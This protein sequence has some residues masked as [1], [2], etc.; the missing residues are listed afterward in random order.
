MKKKLECP[1][2]KECQQKI[3]ENDLDLCEGDFPE[4]NQ[5]DCFKYNDLGQ[6]VARRKGVHIVKTA[7]E[8]ERRHEKN[9]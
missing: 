9:E 2:L 1:H 4:W 3:E 7:S 5:Q 6:E 8:W